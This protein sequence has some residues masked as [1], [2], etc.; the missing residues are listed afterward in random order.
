[1]RGLGA[2]CA[3]SLS[4]VPDQEGCVSGCY[5]QNK[6]KVNNLVLFD[7]TT[8]DKLLNEVPKYK[9]ITP[10]S[11]TARKRTGY[12]CKTCAHAFCCQIQQLLYMHH[13]ARPHQEWCTPSVAAAALRGERAGS[14]CGSA[15]NQSSSAIL[16]AAA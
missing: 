11:S 14:G 10:V 15:S 4:A 6:E 16:K 2:G 7:Q 5:A 13:V 9:M 8:Y 3:K 1:M 12:E